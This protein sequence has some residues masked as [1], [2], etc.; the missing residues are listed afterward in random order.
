MSLSSPHPIFVL[1]ALGI[2]ATVLMLFIAFRVRS[3]GLKVL[4]VLISILTLAPAG[5]VMAA[6][7][8][9]WIDARYRSYKTFFADIRLG[10]TREEVMA[11]QNRL[12]PPDG[13][14]K[15]PTIIVEDERSITFFMHPEHATEP[16]CEG[17]FLAFEN[18]RLKSKTYSPD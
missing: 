2:V 5:L 17:I 18:G 13:P 14:R 6:A 8:P 10:M 15:K 7:Y 1:A 16:N 3:L 9:E 11:V 4:L 12:Y